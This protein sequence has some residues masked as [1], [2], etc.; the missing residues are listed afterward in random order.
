[1]TPGRA[2]DYVFTQEALDQLMTQLMEG[3][4]Q[5]TTRPASQETR[6]A[7][8]RHTVSAASELRTRDCA[9]CKDGFDVG[10]KTVALPCSHSFHDECI[11]PWLE[12]N[13]TCP[14]CRTP[15]RS[16]AADAPAQP[17]PRPGAGSGGGPPSPRSP[18]SP[19]SAGHNP[20]QTMPG[21]LGSRWE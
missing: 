10:Q 11:L 6:D 14:V 4:G 20:S 8:P 3:S 7:L 21:G 15:V 5:H 13:G 2:G 19:R 17:P 9:V 18:R 12:L 1:M 16:D